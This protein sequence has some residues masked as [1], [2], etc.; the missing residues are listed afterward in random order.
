MKCDILT[1]FPDMV[2]AVVSASILGRAREKGLLDI[3]AV[4]LRDYAEGRHK[5]ADDYPYGGGA[6]MVIKPEPVFRA[7]DDLRARD[8][9]LRLV[10][11][12]P[13]GR[14][15]TQAVAEEFAGETRRVVFLCGHYEGIDERVREGLAPE[16]LSVGDYI[17]T[18][19]ELAALIVVDAAARLVPGVLGDQQSA[20]ADSFAGALLDYPHY[21]RPPVY[22]G[23]EVPE[24]LRSGDHEAIRSWRRAQ[25]LLNT[26]S[27]R[28]DLLERAELTPED[29]QVLNE[30]SRE[31]SA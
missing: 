19:G 31:G 28:P 25:S 18:G 20:E 24:I 29:R 12:S 11:M 30:F 5:V 6:G 1:L 26:L 23:L 16:E 27:K 9:D 15:F 13:Q 21:T 17:L 14:R 22:R 10:M 2:E 7:V 3:R 4:N 8:G